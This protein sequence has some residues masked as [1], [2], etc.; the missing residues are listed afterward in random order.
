ML[1]SE[2][3]RVLGLEPQVGGAIAATREMEFRGLAFGNGAETAR[4]PRADCNGAANPRNV[5]SWASSEIRRACA[6]WVVVD[7][8]LRNRSPRTKFP[9]NRENNWEIFEYLAV[10]A[11]I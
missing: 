10:S 8:V 11:E 1:W 7:A 2:Q 6:D 9:V 3:W 5:A 4:K